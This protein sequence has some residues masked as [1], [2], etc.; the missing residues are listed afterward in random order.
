MTHSPPPPRTLRN[1]APLLLRPLS[2]CLVRTALEKMKCGSTPGVDGIPAEVFMSMPSVFVAPMHDVMSAFL[3]QDAI[4][5][6]WALGVMNPGPKDQ[7]STSVQT[8][9]PICLQNVIF[10]WATAIILLMMEDIVAFAPPPP[11]PPQ[12]T[13][14]I[15]HRFIFHHIWNVR[16][17]WEA[18][19]Q[20]VLLSVDF[21]EAYDSV[22]HSY[23]RAFFRYIAPP[24]AMRALRISMFK[25]PL[26]F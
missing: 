11:P 14:F 10:K 1:C 6:A 4:P 20:G 23:R 13:A 19:E 2:T 26:V 16:G 21:S 25:A 7:G 17:A 12:Q 5:V 9:S 15:K 18:V 22:F 3:A 24:P 8:L